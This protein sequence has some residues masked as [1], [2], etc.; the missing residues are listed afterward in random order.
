MRTP[1]VAELRAVHACAVGTAT[2][3]KSFTAPIAGLIVSLKVKEGDTVKQGQELVVIEAMKMENVIFADH[4]TKIKKVS[5]AE[6]ESVQVDQ[7]LM[8][9][10]C[11]VIS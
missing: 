11:G 1:R 7:V 9:F 4:E 10:M 3:K 6:K 2:G 8:E 5:V